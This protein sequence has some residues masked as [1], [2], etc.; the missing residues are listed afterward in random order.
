MST[1]FPC[2]FQSFRI[3]FVFRRSAA[4]LRS[5]FGAPWI[6]WKPSGKNSFQKGL[7][8]TKIKWKTIWGIVVIILLNILV[9]GIV[10]RSGGSLQ[11]LSKVGSTGSEVRQIQT[12]LK[13]WGYYSGA[14]DGI[15]GS[16][17]K[18]AVVYFQKKNGLTADGVAGP[19][20]LAKIGISST[21]G[22]GGAGGMS[23]SDVNLMA[24]VISA[25]SRGEPYVGQVAVGAVILNRIEHPSFPKTLAG[26]IYEPGAFSCIADGGI[27][28]PVASSAY[29][30]ARDALNGWDPSGGAVYYY[31]PAKTTN[32]W[33]LSRPVIVVI[34]SHRFC[35]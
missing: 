3:L 20:T 2:F 19:A 4:D 29:T 9:F 26:V 33:I 23:A 16:A 14:V 13:S 18:K 25:E 17:T 35:S 27:D 11:T 12:R 1:L 7:V 34:G 24:R 15:Y 21:S 31:N 32:K 30:A 6:I 10:T 5:K 28:A 22:D 8:T